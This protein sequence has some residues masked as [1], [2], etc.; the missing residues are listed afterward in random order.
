MEVKDK[1]ISLKSIKYIYDLLKATI[2]TLR[3]TVDQKP[4]CYIVTATDNGVGRLIVDHSTSEIRAAV[5]AGNDARLYDAQTGMYHHLVYGDML[6]ATFSGVEMDSHGNKYAVSYLV[7]S[8]NSVIKDTVKLPDADTVLY[9]DD[10]PGAIDDALEMAKNSGEFVGDTGQR[11]TGFLTI[12][13]GP[14]SHATVVNGINVAN[15][16]SL[17]TVKSQAGVSEV[18]A[19]DTLRHS[20]YLYP[21]IYVDEAYV[22][23]GASMNIRG[24]DGE[25]AMPWYTNVAPTNNYFVISNLSGPAGAIPSPGHMIVSSYTGRGYFITAVDNNAVTIADYSVQVTGN[26]G[27][28]GTN[29]VDGGYYTIDVEQLNSQN[30]KISFTP[31]KAGMTEILPEVITLPQGPQGNPGQDGRDG[32][33]GQPGQNGQPGQD[34]EDGVGISSI[35]QTT[36]S[37]VDGGSNVFTVTLTNGTTATFTVKN[38]S[39]GSTGA[40]GKDGQDGQRGAGLLAITTAPSNYTTVVNGLTPAYRIALST[41]KTEAGVEEVFAGDT[42]RYSYYHYPVIYVDASYVYCRARVSI[43]GGT[44]ATGAAGADGKDYVL[45]EADKEEIAIIANPDTAPDYVEAEAEAV[46]DRV[47]AAQGENTFTFA[48]ISDLHY[49]EGSYTEGIR[50]AC[51]AIRYIDS[52]VKLDA[53]AVL[54]DY[55]DGYPSTGMDNALGDFKAINGMLQK[56]RFAPNL[57]QQGNHDYYADDIPMTRR[58]IQFYSD[59]VVWGSRAGGYYYRDFTDHKLRV[60]CPNTNENNPMDSSTNKPSSSISMTTAQL[61]WLIET[62][63]LSSKDDVED[64]QI[65]ILTH[66]PL[67]YWESNSKYSLSYIVHAYQTGGSWSGNGVSCNFD[68]KNKATLI[69]NIHGHIHNFLMSHMFLGNSNSASKTNVYRMSTPNACVGRENQYAGAWGEGTTYT[70]TKYSGKDTAFVI[71]CINL[72]DHKI[73]AVCYGAGYDRALN[74]LDQTTP[75]I[76]AVINNLTNVTTSNTAATVMHGQGY[77]ATLTPAGSTI[78]SVTVMMGG[79]DV[80]A[81]VYANGIISIPTVTGAIVITAVGTA[82]PTYTNQIPLSIAS[83]GNIYN[84]KG[85]KDNTRLNSSGTEASATGVGVTG[86]I[87][88]KRGDTVYLSGIAASLTATGSL[89]EYTYLALYDASFT[90]K[91]SRK[92]NTIGGSLSSVEYIYDSFTTD[93]ST[94]YVTSFRITDEYNNIV[95]SG[96]YLRISAAGLNGDA[97]ITVN[98]PIG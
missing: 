8:D 86:F 67:D 14:T 98:E 45:T 77:T 2:D 48:A 27:N 57:R 16:I 49:G 69:G 82:A 81:S 23:C 83:D 71:Y 9:A 13:T 78:S 66:H 46:I 75:E 4:E 94:G 17:S 53:V 74:Y 89:N 51:Q 5:D 59:D 63:D 3:E 56:L 72:S 76:Y 91:G 43:R 60:I 30:V 55:T 47:L 50:H 44:G 88:V 95:G 87:P 21:V 20:Y 19:G 90:S 6:E 24:S 29:G 32:Q 36:T 11:G 15:R 54:G 92:F 73:T 26:D 79:V 22:Y 85:W 61:Q 64:W 80:T 62:L 93:P 38:G 68:G 35:K 7:S 12:A 52:R 42:L 1:L 39:K 97:I 25:N 18:F 40:D 65:L 10:L 96:G 41:V 37:S 28:D 70:K 31:S 84:G 58:M 34:G 33:D